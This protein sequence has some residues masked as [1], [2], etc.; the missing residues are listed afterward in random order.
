MTDSLTCLP[1]LSAGWKRL[2]RSISFW[3][4]LG[5]SAATEAQAANRFGG[6]LNVETTLVLLAGVGI[7]L[8][9]AGVLI[10]AVRE[11]RRETHE[12]RRTYLYRRR[13]PGSAPPRSSRA[14]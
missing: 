6:P 4:G 7:L 5:L 3:L 1:R 8:V 11:L 2:H 14:D 13:G 10:V 12:R 9:A